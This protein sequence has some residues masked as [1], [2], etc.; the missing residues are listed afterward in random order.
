MAA[1]AEYAALSSWTSR[2]SAAY[3]WIPDAPAATTT[4]LR[5]PESST[6]T[7]TGPST[8]CHSGHATAQWHVFTAHPARWPTTAAIPTSTRPTRACSISVP[9][10][11]PT[12]DVAGSTTLCRNAGASAAR[13]YT[14]G[15][16][17]AS[18]DTSELW[19]RRW[20]AC[21]SVTAPYAAPTT[22][23]V[24]NWYAATATS[25]LWQH[26]HVYVYG[27]GPSWWTCSASHATRHASDGAFDG[28]AANVWRASNAT[29]CTAHCP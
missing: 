24:A 5:T 14:A 9:T 22:D 28:P 15:S 26:A 1:A 17:G 27:P 25:A 21:S 20:R 16:A 23:S 6:S 29:A 3:V 13:R 18:W 4:A 8:F 11:R 10:C 12:N 7:S 19:G 2:P